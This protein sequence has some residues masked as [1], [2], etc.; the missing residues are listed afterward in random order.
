MTLQSWTETPARTQQPR[1]RFALAHTLSLALVLALLSALSST[2]SADANAD[3]EA[4]IAQ[5][6][7]LRR[8][9]KDAEALEVF[10]RAAETH[11]TPRALAQI[12][13]AQQALGQWV[14][15]EAH[16]KLALDHPNNPWVSRNRDTLG[17]S[18]S[19]VAERLGS[20]EVQC[21]VTGASVTVNGVPA[22][23]TPL[24][25]PLRVVAG[26]AV[27]EV[28]AAGYHP[29]TR[30]LQVSAGSLARETVTLVAMRATAEPP[31]V[32]VDPAPVAGPIA[33]EGGQVDVEGHCCWPGQRWNTTRQH[34]MGAP[35]C[36]EGTIASGITCAPA[37]PTEAPQ[38]RVHETITIREDVVPTQQ[39]SPAPAAPAAPEPA[40]PVTRNEHPAEGG[41][42]SLHV[43]YGG[44]FR[45]DAS[46]FLTTEAGGP[47]AF[48]LGF[49][50]QFAAGYRPVRWVSFGAHVIG[51][52]QEGDEDYWDEQGGEAR[53]LTLSAGAY[54]RGHLVG[55]LHAGAFD[56]W[57]GTGF[58][59]F[60]R[61]W[62][63]AKE[64]PN[65][66]V[67]AVAIPL[68]AGV[69]LFGSSSFGLELKFTM[70][71]WMPL[72]YC[73]STDREYVCGA[74]TQGQTS[75]DAALGFTWVL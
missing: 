41:E 37:P 23:T 67:K 13:L 56:L 32:V 55:D 34:C 69:S 58:H 11:S 40:P 42:I 48:A 71:N 39:P 72:D 54:V 28:T 45:R 18:L 70:L 26:S 16:L 12:G 10:K 29:L 49:V 44:F 21:D 14:A 31:P 9:G 52:V 47:R 17:R 75:W 35:D 3:A 7:E 1:P 51:S 36:P 24:A 46:L 30:N 19:A 15:A 74:T 4:L 6:I 50:G 65:A 43:G 25:E 2:A 20:V 68:E 63:D 61:A 59:P 53:L 33:C 60:S 5:G 8:Q 27:L 57:L 73:V 62:V 22:G 66:L 38:E 64:L